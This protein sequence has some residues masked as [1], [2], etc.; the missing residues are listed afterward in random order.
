MLFKEQSKV[1][2]T[3]QNQREPVPDFEIHSIWLIR[4]ERHEVQLKEQ[5]LTLTL[6]FQSPISDDRAAPLV[7]EE[8]SEFLSFKI[9]FFLEKFD[10]LKNDLLFKI[11]C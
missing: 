5:I 6:R 8:E 9:S 1:G 11:A 3:N 2:S 10:A 7:W 4:K